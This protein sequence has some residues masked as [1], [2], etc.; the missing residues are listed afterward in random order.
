MP[1]NNKNVKSGY[2]KVGPLPLFT[3][4]P[5]RVLLGN[6]KGI[7]RKKAGVERPGRTVVGLGFV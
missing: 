4:S 6:L 3:E 5:G 7:E 1:A 2:R